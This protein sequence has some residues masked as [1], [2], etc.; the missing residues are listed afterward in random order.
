MHLV[1]PCEQ[2]CIY[3]TCSRNKDLGGFH[4]LVLVLIAYGKYG[5][6][7]IESYISFLNSEFYQ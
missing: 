3:N 6:E 4:I 7:D 1:R 2:P 5:C